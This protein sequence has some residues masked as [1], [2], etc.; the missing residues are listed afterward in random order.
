MYGEV[1]WYSGKRIAAVFNSL[2]NNI[3]REAG[4]QSIKWT[5]LMKLMLDFPG[6]WVA[7]VGDSEG[8]ISENRMFYLTKNSLWNGK[9]VADDET[10]PIQL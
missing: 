6:G 5:L 1:I 2:R 10:L 3:K 9:S 8:E 7:G 4:Y